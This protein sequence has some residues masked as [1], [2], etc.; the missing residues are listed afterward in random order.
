V[1]PIQEGTVHLTI[2]GD[3]F[4]ELGEYVPPRTA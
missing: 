2:D 1:G 4:A 3:A